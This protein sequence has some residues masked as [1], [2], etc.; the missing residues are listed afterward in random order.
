[1]RSMGS[2]PFWGRKSLYELLS[3]ADLGGGM[4]TLRH[5]LIDHVPQHDFHVYY[6]TYE[7]YLIAFNQGLMHGH[8]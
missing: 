2:D 4:P 8:Y 7:T 6:T 3:V 5:H 1:M